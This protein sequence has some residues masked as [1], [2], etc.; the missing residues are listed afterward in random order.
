MIKSIPAVV[1][2]DRD[3]SFICVYLLFHKKTLTG[4]KLKMEIAIIILLVVVIAILIYGEFFFK[5]KDRRN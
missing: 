5:E 4:D 2:Y 3:V 1:E